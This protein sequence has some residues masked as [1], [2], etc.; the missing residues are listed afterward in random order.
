MVGPDP[1]RRLQLPEIAD[2]AVTAVRFALTRYLAGGKD[3]S[4]VD[5][6][7]VFHF[8]LLSWGFYDALLTG[9]C[10]CRNSMLIKRGGFLDVAVVS[11]T[12]GEHYRLQGKCSAYYQ[13]CSTRMRTL[14]EMDGYG[15]TFAVQLLIS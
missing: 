8:S 3:D 10:T 2:R 13:K 1:R 6:P 12:C 15:R 7:I 11:G 14:S 9:K 5:A 4:S